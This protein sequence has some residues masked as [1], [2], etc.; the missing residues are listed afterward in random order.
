ML[1]LAL[2]TA[3]FGWAVVGLISAFLVGSG[4]STVDMSLSGETL[5]WSFVLL[6]HWIF[7][8]TPGGVIG[9]FGVYI[10]R[11]GGQGIRR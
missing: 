7:Y 8:W 11:R 3:G 2:M 1:G 10:R 9:L 4:A 5:L 6:S